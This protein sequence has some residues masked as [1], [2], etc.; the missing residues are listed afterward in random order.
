MPTAAAASPAFARRPMFHDPH[1]FR[2]S[3]RSP[4]EAA[5]P[6]RT[7]RQPS[8]VIENISR[9]LSNAR[10][11]VA[12]FFT[13]VTA[14]RPQHLALAP[15]IRVPLPETATSSSSPAPARLSSSLSGVSSP[16]AA[17]SQPAV[18]PSRRSA[19]CLPFG[20]FSSDSADESSD[21][22]ATSSLLADESNANR[23][24]AIDEP[25]TDQAAVQGRRPS[26]WRSFSNMWRGRSA[27]GAR[28]ALQENFAASSTHCLGR[29]GGSYQDLSGGPP[30]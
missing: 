10:E 11:A 1:A 27:S 19:S 5:R 13:R 25:A 2:E 24:H 29:G 8:R 12:G 22:S 15:P 17:G 18:L 26:L 3:G 30:T 7:P 16:A 28:C 20:S 9:S 14:P 21:V 6:S 23:A 4:L